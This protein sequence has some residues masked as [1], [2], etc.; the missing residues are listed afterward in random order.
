M[1]INLAMYVNT[2]GFGK[3]IADLEEMCILSILKVS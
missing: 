2:D 1:C 3:S